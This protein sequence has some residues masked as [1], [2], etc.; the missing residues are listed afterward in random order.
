MSAVSITIERHCT[1]GGSIKAKSRPPAPAEAIVAIF[2][3]AHT[4]EGHGPASAQQ[5]R[6]A[7]RREDRL[8]ATQPTDTTET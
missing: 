3:E 6:N 1:C 7:R 8:L 4:G 2:A 5:A